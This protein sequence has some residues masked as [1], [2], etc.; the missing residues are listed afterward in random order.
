M[1]FFAKQNTNSKFL[2][3][4]IIF[5]ITYNLCK[6]IEIYIYARKSTHLLVIP[7]QRTQNAANSGLQTYKKSQP[8]LFTCHTGASFSPRDNLYNWF[9][10]VSFPVGPIIPCSHVLCKWSCLLFA[11][12]HSQ[13]TITPT[14]SMYLCKEL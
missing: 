6:P 10:K 4:F 1:F 9:A 7:H 12:S 2:V 11:L 14:L 5:S 3:C 13:E 8:A